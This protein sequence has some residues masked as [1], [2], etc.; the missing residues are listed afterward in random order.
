[1]LWTVI[2]DDLFDACDC[3]V[4]SMPRPDRPSTSSDGSQERF[5]LL[6]GT[7][8]DEHCQSRLYFL[9]YDPSVECSN[10]G[11]RH[12][13][14]AVRGVAEVTDPDVALRN[15]V[16]NVLVGKLAPKKTTDS[17]KVL[18]LSNYQCKL[19]S[20]LLTEY[21]MDKQGKAQPLRS[22]NQNDIFDCANLGG[23][24]FLIQPEHVDIMGYGRDQT[25]SAGYLKNTLEQIRLVNGDAEVLIPIHADGDGHCLVHGISRALVGREL[26]WHALRT[27]LKRH[28]E[29]NLAQYQALFR[30]FVDKDEWQHI[31]QES[32]P[33]YF[34]GPNE[35]MGLQNIHIFGLANV[36]RRPIILLDSLSGLQSFGD[37][38]GV[39]LPVLH[40]R[41]ECRGKDGT[42]NKPLCVAWSSSG[43]N[44]FIALVGV[45]GRP[46]P[47][48]PRWMLTKAW[49]TPQEAI[50]QYIEFDAD[51]MCTIGGERT[52]QE[53]YVQRLATAMEGLFLDKH[54]VHPSLVSDAYN[55]IYKRA[56]V[57]DIHQDIIIQRTRYAVQEHQLYSCLMCKAVCQLPSLVGPADRGDL[58]RGGELYQL[59][60]EING[61]LEEGKLY[62][63]HANDLQCTYD[64]VTDELVPDLT[65]KQDATCPWCQ[66]SGTTHL[67][68]LKADG[69]IVYVNGDR[70]STPSDSTTC[71][72]GHKHYWGGVEYDNPPLI[73]SVPLSWKGQTIEEEVVWFQN[74]GQPELNS[75]A[76]RIAEKLVNRH[77]AGEFGNEQLVQK[78]V[79]SI[80]Q[81]TASKEPAYQPP[82]LTNVPSASSAGRSSPGGSSSVQQGGASP[83]HLAG[84]ERMDAAQGD[85]AESPRRQP[86]AKSKEGSPKRIS[87]D[88]QS[89]SK[90]IL[91]GTKK[92]KKKSTVQTP[93]SKVAAEVKSPQ[94]VIIETG[95]TPT[96]EPPRDIRIKL[97]HISLASRTSYSQL[98]ALIEAKL[99]V[100]PARQRIKHGFPPKEL[101]APPVG[102]E[103]TAPLLLQNGDKLT[104]EVLPDPSSHREDAMQSRRTTAGIAG[105]RQKWAGSSEPGLDQG[106]LL[107]EFQKGFKQIRDND[108][109][110]AEVQLMSLSLMAKLNGM[111]LWTFSKGKPDLFEHG[112]LFYNIVE[113]DLGLEDGK[114]CMLPSI[115]EKRFRYSAPNDRLELCLEP[116]GHFP[117]NPDVDDLQHLQEVALGQRSL[118]VGAVNPVQDGE[119]ST[120][121]YVAFAGR[122]HSL[123]GGVQEIST[124]GDG[125]I[126]MKSGEVDDRVVDRPLVEDSVDVKCSGGNDDK[127]LNVFDVSG[128][129]QYRDGS[130]PDGRDQPRDE[131]ESSRL[132]HKQQGSE[133]RSIPGCD[134]PGG[135]AAEDNAALTGD[136]QPGSSITLDR[137]DGDIP[138]DTDCTNRSVH[139]EQGHRSPLPME[140]DSPNGEDG[141]SSHFQFRNAGEA[142]Q[143]SSGRME[144]SSLTGDSQTHHGKSQESLMSRQIS[145]DPCSPLP[146]HHIQ[147]AETSPGAHLES[148]A[149]D[150]EE[151]NSAQLC[152]ST[153]S[154]SAT[155]SLAA[156]RPEE[157]I[158]V[159]TPNEES[160]YVVRRLGPG[161]TV[162]V[163]KE[164]GNL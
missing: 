2:A 158:H 99:H 81:N 153:A 100:P 10:C 139:R 63:F 103:E 28:F 35:L 31:I 38:S 68:R 5:C 58:R 49:G 90:I 164:D 30:D 71:D 131:M 40:S 121:G 152:T 41:N 65:F 83:R 126:S 74:E 161:Y 22:L 67:R 84:S 113:R 48:L 138:M 80:L 7:C 44:H 108:A 92:E 60:S 136:G 6:S 66:G 8:P 133:E 25:G 151:A 47:R 61:E 140:V 146:Q 134:G 55:Y 89:P 17:V 102:E 91:T 16:R 128:S 59:A 162:L 122:G 1:M 13:L 77:F 64:P 111:D 52:L 143:N 50:N 24:A 54:G 85:R 130:I 18:G 29:Q 148:G 116:L 104:V 101:R 132:E 163:K 56:G 72:C 142:S 53:K 145:T 154:T 98:Q 88:V 141:A 94:Q 26:F 27:N 125:K 135:V 21:G 160:G 39:F 70:T 110:N 105:N 43:R 37:Y 147:A 144:G 11:Q 127:S 107:R 51:D 109:S 15:M 129:V 106:A 69:S 149:A 76:F 34:P 57:V 159:E 32:D 97:S 112:G 117:I 62:T 156:I 96:I 86:G 157:S 79:E 123:S 33:D 120:S 119:P 75:N 155:P 46:L 12:P 45:K 23:R 95:T 115:P 82:S 19:L 20:P 78:V 36:L 9:S 14:D 150:Q 4:C 3:R 87:S 114:H 124:E 73:F 93:G 42:L 137:V 118:E